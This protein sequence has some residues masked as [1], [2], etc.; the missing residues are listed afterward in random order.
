MFK[1]GSAALFFILCMK[2]CSLLLAA[3]SQPEDSACFAWAFLGFT[4]YVR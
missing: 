1:E 4:A 3:L 2:G